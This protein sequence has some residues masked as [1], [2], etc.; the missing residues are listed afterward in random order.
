MVTDLSLTTT[1]GCGT[2]DLGSP[3]RR[4]RKITSRKSSFYPFIRKS[5]CSYPSC[6]LLCLVKT[7]FLTPFGSVP[8]N[9]KLESLGINR[10]ENLPQPLP[11]PPTHL[12]ITRLT[13]H[14]SKRFIK[15]QNNLVTVLRLKW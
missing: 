12:P 3:S 11:H 2:V 6:V 15:D 10:V 8:E 5:F 13:F 7:V 4:S 1:E 9:G 14:F